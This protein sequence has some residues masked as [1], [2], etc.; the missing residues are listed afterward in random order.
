MPSF[1]RSEIA[2]VNENNTRM[3]HHCSQMLQKKKQQKTFWRHKLVSDIAQNI[4][5]V[6]IKQ[7]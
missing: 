6:K 4:I 1:Q 3:L 5:M 7:H 2:T